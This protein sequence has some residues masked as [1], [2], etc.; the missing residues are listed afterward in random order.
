MKK[1]LIDKFYSDSHIAANNK[2]IKGVEYISYDE[3][4]RLLTIWE[5]NKPGFSVDYVLT[6]HDEILTKVEAL[7]YGYKIIRKATACEIIAYEDEEAHMR[8]EGEENQHGASYHE[9]EE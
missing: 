1:E 8:K 5:M 9:I 6:E 4:V 2:L 7:K 3:F